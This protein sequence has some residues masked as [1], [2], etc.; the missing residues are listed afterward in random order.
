MG[1]K[2]EANYNLE[3]NLPHKAQGG[4]ATTQTTERMACPQLQRYPKAPVKRIGSS[5]RSYPARAGRAAC[6]LGSGDGA[7]LVYLCSV[8]LSNA[9]RSVCICA[10]K[11]RFRSNGTDQVSGCA[12]SIARCIAEFLPRYLEFAWSQAYA[13][14]VD[15]H[16]TIASEHLPTCGPQTLTSRHLTQVPY[17][18]LHRGR[19]CL[20]CTVLC[21]MRGGVSQWPEARRGGRPSPR[22]AREAPCRKWNRRALA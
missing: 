18:L 8:G 4:V 12:G 14:A 20:S 9:V 3:P 15:S 16:F 19:R 6:K 7:G 10:K 11:S 22:M 1:V 21:A 2:A 17:A 13:P 5:P